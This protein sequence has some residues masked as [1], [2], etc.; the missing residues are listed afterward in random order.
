MVAV[1]GQS[2]TIVV[3]D[4]PFDRAGR[5]AERITALIGASGGHLVQQAESGLIATFA[6]LGEAMTAVSAMFGASELERVRCAVVDRDVAAGAGFDSAVAAARDLCREARP[7]QAVV[8]NRWAWQRGLEGRHRE[9]QAL[10]DALRSAESGVPEVLTLTG[11]LGAGRTTLLERL[12]DEARARGFSVLGV[13]AVGGVLGGRW[14]SLRSAVVAGSDGAVTRLADQ[15]AT[16][17]P[18]VDAPD[19]PAVARELLTFL[20]AGAPAWLVTIDDIEQLDDASRSAVHTLAAGLA[21]E[22]CVLVATASGDPGSWLDGAVI[23]LPDLTH[24]QVSRIVERDGP[25]APAVLRRCIELA[26]GNPL[27]AHEVSRALSQRQRAGHEPMPVIPEPAAAVLAGFRSLLS[28]APEPAQRA[29]VVVAADDTGDS[30]VV[31]A[32]LARLGEDPAC[33]LDA[34]TSGIVRLDGSRVQLAHPL[35]RSVAYH[36]VAAGSRRAAHQ[37]LAAVLDRP[38]Q[39]TARAYQLA[40]AA[41]GPSDAA[42]DALLLV[43]DTEVRRGDVR[44]AARA[45]ATAARLTADEVARDQ[46]LSRAAILYLR[47][48]DLDAVDAALAERDDPGTDADALVARCLLA[49]ERQGPAQAQ[50]ELRRV[51][52]PPSLTPVVEA[53]DA[54]AGVLAGAAP[55]T[56]PSVPLAVHAR[57]LA[58]IEPA[59]VLLNLQRSPGALGALEASAAAHA[60]VVAGW[61]SEATARVREL[62]VDAEAVDPA[63]LRATAG[64]LALEAGRPIAA[65]EMLGDAE[66][67]RG[68]ATSSDCLRLLA[69]GRARLLCGRLDDAAASLHAAAA[70]VD[71]LGLGIHQVELDLLNGLLAHARGHA[72]ALELLGRAARVRPER[73]LPHLVLASLD[74]RAT[75]RS[76]WNDGLRS[77][78]ESSDPRVSLAARR[79]AAAL[80]ADIEELVS[81]EKLC[82]EAGLELEATLTRAAAVATALRIGHPD[83]SRLADDFARHAAMTG[84]AH[85][86]T[87]QTDGG[88]GDLRGLLSPAE[89]RVAV[90]VGTGATNKEVSAQLFI[91]VKTVDYHLQNIYRKI[92]ARSRTELAV[93]LA[94]G[95]PERGSR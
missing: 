94:G 95:Q 17:A 20:T 77:L 18:T 89:L 34:E 22:R 46:R 14:A 50:T 78:S 64:L 31:R 16:L 69:L 5:V 91:S 56:A 30:E 67:T 60:L 80:S 47:A 3:V 84:T 21:A 45:C 92:G 40:A 70:V 76:E 33:L 74:S 61:T 48:G 44:A 25:I 26:G 42:S 82:A 32:A 51:P 19:D 37:A 23:A 90:A 41:S 53:L 73:A 9:W 12:E 58:G 59:T 63:A 87:R 24:D 83:A 38:R 15:L 62:E 52:V 27:A 85:P 54:Y 57:V 29:A 71:R 2:P 68:V 55:T 65:L 75:P 6:S 7:G 8:A 81:V 79:A 66:A 49:I 28:R 4:V 88:A 86:G 10:T 36:Q 43:A 11:D 39:A 93:L 72:S 35:L 1:D 13:R